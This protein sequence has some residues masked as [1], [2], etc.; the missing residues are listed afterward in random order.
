VEPESLARSFGPAALAE[1]H[2]SVVVFIGDCAYKLKK[3][4]DLGFVDHT[5]RARREAACH[6]EVR[7]NRRFAPDVYLGVADVHGP[8]GSVCDHLVT[9]RRMPD[10][11]RLAE[12]VRRG[13]P[14]ED[15]LW[16]IAHRIATVHAASPT[17][18]EMDATAT[19]TAVRGRWEDSFATM[20]PFAGPVLDATAVA[21][22]EH[23]ARR[24]LDGREPLF[25]ARIRERRIR[26]GHG[27]LLAED[28]F[29]LDDGPRILDCL[30]FD[31][32]LRWGDVLA[33][34]AF[35]A[36]DLEYLGRADLARRF[37]AGYRELSAETWPSSLAEHYIAYRAH[38]RSKVMCLR[39]AQGEPAAAAARDLLDLTLRHLERGRVRLV[40]VG[41]LP[42]SGKSTLAASLADAGVGVILGSDETRKELAGLS[43][44]TP[45]AAGFEAGLYRPDHT[46]AT[47][48]ELLR[49]S[50]TLLGLGQSVIL[51]ATWR[52]EAT[53][54][55]A[56]RLAASASADVI[57]LHCGTP[58]ALATARV[59]GRA[60]RAGPSDATPVVTT[61]IAAAFD[62]WP[63][64]VVVDTTMPVEWSVDAAQDA[65][66]GWDAA[67]PS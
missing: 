17:A 39:Q 19:A 35:L 7:L 2:V 54:A 18:P 50:R 61:A 21:R 14:V 38:V 51:D 15:H 42:G 23:L 33:D 6:A 30:E 52:D 24:Y 27:D 28:I 66:P 26:D 56:R 22:V 25:T 11:R 63:S 59:A 31:P 20:R 5:T 67:R 37:L 29:C 4:V 34:V 47:Y 58:L 55:S 53:R 64:A 40:L 1:T 36:M 48:Q 12:L 44:T 9:M 16:D 62:P 8:D 60:G 32:H 43:P 3:P 45:S 49:R 57:E 46:R 65:I 41:G 10:D 13:L